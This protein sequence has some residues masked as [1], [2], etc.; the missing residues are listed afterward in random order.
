M[1]GR[2]WRAKL[3]ELPQFPSL[4][5]FP[6][7]LGVA[8]RALPCR[9]VRCGYSLLRKREGG[10]DGFEMKSQKIQTAQNKVLSHFHI[11]TP[12]FLEQCINLAQILW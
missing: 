8:G 7:A 5:A 3:Q 1:N 11:T 12:F 4:R 9:G 2:N 10:L 6:L